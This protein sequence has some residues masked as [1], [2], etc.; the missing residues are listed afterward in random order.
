MPLPKRFADEKLTTADFYKEVW[1]V[2]PQ[3]RKRAVATVDFEKCEARL[4]CGKCSYNKKH[5]TAIRRGEKI[6][7]SV[8]A[9][10]QYYFRASLWLQMPFGD[11]RLWAYNDKH[12][13]YMERYI[14]ALLRESP[15]RTGF[16][17]VEKLPKFIQ[18]ASNREPLLKLIEKMR[19]TL[20]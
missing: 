4:V 6:I 13:D 8:Q 20:M 9:A 10:A 19:K 12:L 7:G 14:G 3:C 2:C 17:L 11:H 5:S 1:V 16:T 18:H 15:N